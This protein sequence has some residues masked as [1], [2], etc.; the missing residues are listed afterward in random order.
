VKR[1]RFTDAAVLQVVRAHILP[2]TI[3]FTSIMEALEATGTYTVESL[4]GYEWT[5]AFAVAGELVNASSNGTEGTPYPVLLDNHNLTEPG[6]F[7]FK[8]D[9]SDAQ[10]QWYAAARLH[11]L[12][13]LSH[14]LRDAA[15]SSEGFTA[16]LHRFGGTCTSAWVPNVCARYR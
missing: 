11:P 7:D 5:F 3:T 8:P 15:T 16:A 10:G 12:D 4:Q 1:W 6:F 14:A 13:S 2:G 9:I